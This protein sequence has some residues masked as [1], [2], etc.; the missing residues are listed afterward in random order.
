AFALSMGEMSATIILMRP[1]LST[2]PIAVYG[3]LSARQFGAA[4]AMAVVLIIVTAIAFISIDRLG[5][6]RLNA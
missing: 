1:G 3:L 4:S 5:G 6:R 2:I